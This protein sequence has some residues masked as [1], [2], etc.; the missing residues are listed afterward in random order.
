MAV[1]VPTQGSDVTGTIT[2]T[3]LD[4]G[5]VRVT[6]DVVGL[7]PGSEHAWHIH[8]FGNLSDPHGKATGGHYNPKGH[9]HGLPGNADRH[10]GDFGNLTADDTGRAVKRFEVDNITI[11][12]PGSAILGRGF[13]IHA[14]GDDGGQPTGNAGARIAQGVIGVAQPTE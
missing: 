7:E 1:L 9:S 5:Q 14:K 13:I 8:E 2:F 10:A 3:Q 4:D 11:A 12:G 6:A